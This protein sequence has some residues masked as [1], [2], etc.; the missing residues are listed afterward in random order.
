[1]SL[2]AIWLKLKIRHDN[3]DSSNFDPNLIETIT[4]KLKEEVRNESIKN[5][6]RDIQ[7]RFQHNSTS[8]Q[9]ANA[10]FQ[11]ASEL[12]IVDKVRKDFIVIFDTL[13]KDEEIKI[14]L[15]SHFVNIKSKIDILN[16]AYKDKIEPETLN[17]ISIIVER[18]L[19]NILSGIIIEYENVIDDY[20]NIAQVVIT[21]AYPIDNTEMIEKAIANMIERE[22]SMT[23]KVDESLISGIIVD[24]GGTVYDYSILNELKKMKEIVLNC[25]VSDTMTIKSNNIS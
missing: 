23:V 19:I 18:N 3:M 25:D 14:F 21:T 4:S 11:V 22:I 15:S 24:I 12:N 7:E 13:L 17:L 16:K 9:Y 20:Y 6:I 8:L 10:M 5:K 1:M 2:L